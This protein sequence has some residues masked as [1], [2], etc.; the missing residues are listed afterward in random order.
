MAIFD[1]LRQ[2]LLNQKR[3]TT[4]RYQQS[5]FLIMLTLLGAC[6]KEQP[7]SSPFHDTFER[8]E[9]GSNYLNTG[10]NYQILNGQLNIKGAYNHPLWFKRM[11]PHDAIIEFDVASKSSEGDIKVEAW[12]DGQSYAPTQ[13]GY[14]ATSYVFVMGGW[15]NQ[16]T[17]LCRLDEHGADRQVRQDLR[18]EMNR[19]YHWK[20]QRKGQLIEWSVDG[21]PVLSFNDPAPLEGEHHAFFGF[22]NWES[23]LFFDNLKITPLKTA[24]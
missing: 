15:G 4:L 2:I 19:L 14:L 22:N 6:K 18:V 16:L 21:K 20:I 10:A 24:P 11:L 12:G 17:A 5:T 8:A 7:I 13:G 1:G 23:D 9:V 3:R